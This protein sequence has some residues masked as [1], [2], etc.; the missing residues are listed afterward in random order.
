MIKNSEKFVAGKNGSV[1]VITVVSLMIMTALGI[2]MLAISY[3]ARQQALMQKNETA[4][5]LAAE[6]GYEKA[7]FWMSQQQDMLSTLYAGSS[8]TAGAIAFTDAKC[9]YT[10]NFYSFINAK[11][12]YRIIS[13]GH[14]GQFNRTIDTLVM[15]AITGWAMGK[16]RIPDSSTSTSPVYYMS[17]EVIDM[18]LNIN[19]LHD[20]PDNMDIYIS[21][22]PQFLQPVCMGESQ[23]SK[24]SASTL[25]LFD[26]GIYFNQPDSRVVDEATVQ[27]KVDR[28]KDSTAAAYRYTPVASTAVTNSLPAVQ[29]EFFVDTDGVGKVRITNNCTVK[30]FKQSSND[31][32]HDFK[33]TPGSS[34]TRFE[35]YFIY[36]HHYRSNTELRPV[37]TLAQTY[38]SQSFGGVQSAPGGQIFVDG[39]VI[40]GSGSDSDLP[41]TKNVVKGKIAVVATGN[42]WIANT[43][44]VEGAH[45]AD[46]R[47]SAGNPN[48][49]GLISQSVIKVVDPGM[50][51]YTNSYPSYYPGPPTSPPAGLI[52][53][54][55]ANHQSGSSN[56]YDRLLPHEMVV[57]IAVTIGGG[58]WGAEN[59]NKGSY[60]GR[61]EYVSG[62]QDDLVLRG[63]ITEAC[64]GV[65]GSGNDGYLKHYYLDS[66]LLEGVLPGD[67]W[68]QGKYIPAPAG[69]KDYRN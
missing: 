40:I 49:I 2:G 13:N 37:Y 27:K 51:R 5:M 69:W 1:L 43:I 7:I 16:C 45:D 67:F 55:V 65:V 34:G 18:P 25:A 61:R 23:G 28:F 39:N 15:Q 42:I 38:V 24:Y 53:V 57:E 44:T 12:I 21:G 36:A 50:S 6:A 59:V 62:T 26:G 35:R 30:G 33:I 17:G 22:S 64:R 52:Y 3:G 9:D 31:R 68:L 10:I 47:P 48:V 14:S 63:A 54:P 58:G 19:N 8:D 20:S 66:R 32:T 46:G 11:P 4:A 60:G 29:L 41:G 56:T